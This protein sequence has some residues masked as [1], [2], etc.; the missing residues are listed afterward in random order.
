MSVI[1]YGR[2]LLGVVGA[3][4]AFRIGAGPFVLCLVELSGMAG[5]RG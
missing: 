3:Y 2:C 1:A 4:A 5:R